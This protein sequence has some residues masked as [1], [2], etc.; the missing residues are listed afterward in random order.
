MNG[1]MSLRLPAFSFLSFIT[2]WKECLVWWAPFSFEYIGFT[3]QLALGLF[4][5]FFVSH[6]QRRLI[7]DYCFSLTVE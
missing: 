6:T 7:Y 4:L 1:W 2:F 3:A 5:S